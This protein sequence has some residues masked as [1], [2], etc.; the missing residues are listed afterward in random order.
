MYVGTPPPTPLPAI[1][2]GSEL[3]TVEYYIYLSIYLGTPPPTPLP[4]IPRSSD[5][6]HGEYSHHPGSGHREISGSLQVRLFTICFIQ[7][8]LYTLSQ[9]R[10][11]AVLRSGLLLDNI[12]LD[13]SLF[14]FFLVC[15]ILVE[16]FLQ[17]YT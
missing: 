4:A 14:C 11:S 16:S 5:L 15:H 9:K 1:P 3:S 13:W 10:E 12:Y 8:V 7:S 17:L 2:R 6:P